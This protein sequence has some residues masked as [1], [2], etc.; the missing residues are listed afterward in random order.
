MAEKSLFPIH[1][2]DLLRWHRRDS[3]SESVTGRPVR[4]PLTCGVQLCLLRTPVTT[5][6]EPPKNALW[7]LRLNA[8]RFVK[9]MKNLL[10]STRL[11]SS[12]RSCAPAFGSWCRTLLR[13]TL[14]LS[15]APSRV[16]ASLTPLSPD[17][18]VCDDDSVLGRPHQSHLAGR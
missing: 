11:W 17:L 10:A 7:R 6:N 3:S 8:T 12:K 14:E 18:V 1:L 2:I 15:S 4:S 16:K 13:P 9:F 5:A